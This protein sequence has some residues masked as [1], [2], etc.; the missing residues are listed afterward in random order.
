MDRN[1]LHIWST[2][3]GVYVFILVN[4]FFICLGAFTL[5]CTFE[6]KTLFPKVCWECVQFYCLQLQQLITVGK[7][8]YLY[9]TG[10]LCLIRSRMLFLNTKKSHSGLYNFACKVMRRGLGKMANVCPL[11]KLVWHVYRPS[12]QYMFKMSPNSSI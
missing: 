9:N 1:P 10:N 4:I 3:A 12:L 6:K 7:V 8:I 2:H 11:F 5:F